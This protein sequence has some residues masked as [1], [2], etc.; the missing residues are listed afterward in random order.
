MK[1]IMILIVALLMLL[2]GCSASDDG[3]Q[4][5]I[6]ETQPEV[7]WLKEQG[8]PWDQ[9]GVLQ[10]IPINIPAGMQYSNVLEFG[11]DLLAW[12]VDDHLL[13]QVFLELCLIS[14]DDGSVIACRDIPVGGYA[15]PQPLG[16]SLYICDNYSGLVLQLDQ[17]LADVRTW[18]LEPNEDRWYFGGNGRIYQSVQ[19]NW[20]WVYD[21]ETE[22]FEP[23]LD[24]D[25]QISFTEPVATYLPLEYYDAN[26]GTLTY[27]ILDLMTGEVTHPEKAEHY[28][29]ISA[30]GD[31]WISERMGTPFTYRYCNG[32]A[33]PV[34]FCTDGYYVRL[35]QDK[36]LLT[37]DD[38]KYL[39]LYDLNGNPLS[40]C[41]VSETG[42]CMTSNLIWNEEQGGYYLVLYTFDSNLRLLFW[43]I[44]RGTDREKLTFETIPE[45]SQEEAAL[46]QRCEQIG[47]EHGLTVW[48]GDNC[49]TNFFDF[50][51]STATDWVLVDEALDDLEDV[52]DDY[53]A[54][55]FRQLQRKSPQGLQIQLV[56]DLEAQCEMHTLCFVLTTLASS[57]YVWSRQTLT[58]AVNRT[59]PVSE[60]SIKRMMSILR[61]HQLIQ[62]KTGYG[63]YV[64]E[65]GKKFLQYCQTVH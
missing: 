59:T 52:L 22:K 21:T 27:A 45:P 16:D 11:G 4:P 31:V 63:S 13:D 33:A 38:S 32:V 19:S 18:K 51:A 15:V 17:K 10:E 24:G 34:S 20:L 40:S 36:L 60:S 48:I 12:S 53:P 2:C 58:E 54:G 26:T 37:S 43:D 39:H 28:G 55:F 65:L 30:V 29:A 42:C 1:R 14:L 61:Q 49:D 44:S 7:R 35:L 57:P 64:T 25:P 9:D 5:E 41:Q 23:V 46:L 6:S 8:K 56:C 62:S 47:I 3:N 50:T